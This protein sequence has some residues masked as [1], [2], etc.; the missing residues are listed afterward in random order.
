MDLSIVVLSYNT[1]NTTLRCLKELDLLCS[2]SPQLSIELIVVD[3]ASTDGSGEAL[4][5]CSFQHLQYIPIFNTENVGFSK[6]NNIALQHARGPYVLFLN[7]DVMVGV[8]L[9]KKIVFSTLLSYLKTHPT[10]G[11]LTIRLELTNGMIDPASH[12]GFPSPWRSFTYFTRL[13]R[14]VANHIQNKKLQNVFG[15][16]HLLGKDLSTVHE[17]E[18]GTAAFML[19]RADVVKELGGFDERF[20]MYGEDLDLCYRMWAKGYKM[21]WY[22]KYTAVHLKYQSG[23]QARLTDVQKKIRWHFYD[24][25]GLF[26]HKHY[27]QHTSALTNWLINTFIGLQK[28]LYREKKKISPNTL[29][30]IVRIGIDARLMYQTGVGVYVRN[31][32]LHLAKYESRGIEFYVYA[33]DVDIAKFRLQDTKLYKIRKLVFRPTPYLWHSF[34]EQLGFLMQLQKDKLDLMHFTYASWPFLY[35]RPFIATI[36]DTTLL[37]HATGNASTKPHWWYWIK[38]AVFRFVFSQQ[39]QRARSIIVPSQSVK[40]DL[41]HYYPSHNTKMN[42]V[43]EGVD[44]QFIHAQEQPVD[45]MEDKTYF[46]YV[47]NCY[48]H[49]NVNMLLRTFSILHE[50]QPHI[51]LC[52][53]G[54]NNMFS[55]RLREKIHDIKL[56]DRVFMFHDIPVSQL[57]WLYAHAQSLILPS[58]AEGFG[59]PIVEAL[60]T[61]C[62]LILSQIPV[63][64]EIARTEASFFNPDDRDTLLA[65][66]QKAL[67]EKIIPKKTADVLQ[68]LT[69]SHMTERIFQIYNKVLT[70]S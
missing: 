40:D 58:H 66:M 47:G 59:L 33:Q 68:S 54:P 4:K 51:F 62:P 70:M 43:Y 52:L 49:K 16:Y 67:S 19:C 1:K 42:V 31:L 57:K 24:A 11:A 39:V 44:E 27:K 29:K 32:I 18:A 35:T 14:F 26:Y 3:N 8:E 7:S 10:V 53:V 50:T 69:F 28:Y 46:L 41:T 9:H 30:K 6:G 48:P 17:I 38:H 21:V 23:L 12:R 2:N 37:S 13:E 65:L 64:K 15:G 36:H 34:G 63:F 5:K 45:S 25:M 56:S 20:F 60:Y 61:K 55:E 22:P